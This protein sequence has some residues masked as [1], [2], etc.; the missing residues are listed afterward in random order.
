MNL[1]KNI[2]YKYSLI[3]SSILGTGLAFLC[4]FGIKY[5]LGNLYYNSLSNFLNVVT[6]ISV[7]DFGI[8]NYIYT[9]SLAEKKDY[10]NDYRTFYLLYSIILIL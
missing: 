7:I 10:F 4:F 3:I 8:P 9:K 2:I 1:F 6:I 5:I